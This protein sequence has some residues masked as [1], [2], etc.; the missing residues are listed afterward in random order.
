MKIAIIG[1]GGVGG[2]FGARLAAAGEDVSFIQRGPHLH[3]M[4][5]KGLQVESEE[6]DVSLWPVK[7]AETAENLGPVDIVLIAVKSGQT[8]VAA[9]FCRPLLGAKTGVISLQN[10][11]EN[12]PKL[13][14]WIGRKHVL[15]GVVYILS[16]IKSPG[17]IRHSGKTARLL[18]GELDGSDTERCRAFLASCRKARIDAKFTTEI[19]AE[20]WDKFVFLCPH[21]G[22]TA[23]TRCPIGLVREDPDCR[24]LLE[25]AAGEVI[26][27]AKAHGI[28]IRSD[29]VATYMTRFDKLP[30]EMTSSMHYDVMHGKALELDWLN[31]AV[32]RLGRAKGVATPIND[33]IYTAL[34]LLRTGV[35]S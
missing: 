8:E 16:L 7:V 34:K 11:V 19:E 17:L 12:E 22:M 18:F 35:E 4:Q 26:S 21:N 6:G 25:E 2:Y 1:A 23:L 14:D 27:L 3:A 28:G 10:G 24:R 32:G 31:G 33:F 9:R 13:A 29:Q 15:G 5:E 30:A 20:L